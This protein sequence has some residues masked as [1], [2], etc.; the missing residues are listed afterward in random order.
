MFS[1]TI[2]VSTLPSTGKCELLFMRW[3]ILCEIVPSKKLLEVATSSLT[4]A[5]TLGD[6]ERIVNDKPFSNSV[7]HAIVPL[8]NPLHYI[9]V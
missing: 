2:L 9:C 5:I 8:A 6:L 3:M 4:S 1:I 7:S